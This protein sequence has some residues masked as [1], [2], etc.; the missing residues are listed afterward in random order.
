MTNTQLVAYEALDSGQ[1]PTAGLTVD[2]VTET[3][4]LLSNTSVNDPFF[5]FFYCGGSRDFIY[6]CYKYQPKE[7]SYTYDDDGACTKNDKYDG[8]PRIYAGTG[9]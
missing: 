2:N 1:S 5:Q 6:T 9:G 7:S 4:S 8:H 3:P